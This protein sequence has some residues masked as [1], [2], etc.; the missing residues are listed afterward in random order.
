MAENW[1]NNI[2]EKERLQDDMTFASFFIAVYE[3]MIDYVVSSIHD[4]L[5]DWGIKDCKEHWTETKD[6]KEKRRLKIDKLMIKEI[7]T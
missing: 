5:C 7:K 2:V 1:I 6:Y 3:N 4:L